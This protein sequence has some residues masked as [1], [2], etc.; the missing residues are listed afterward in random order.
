M[1]LKTYLSSEQSLAK[2]ITKYIFI[3][4]STGKPR[5]DG[6]YFFPSVF[7]VSYLFSSVITVSIVASKRRAEERVEMQ[8]V[9]PAASHITKKTG[10]LTQILC[11]TLAVEQKEYSSSFLY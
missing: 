3:Y 8:F 6:P 4:V 5:R 7:S 10:S 2:L 1:M 11:L 9:F